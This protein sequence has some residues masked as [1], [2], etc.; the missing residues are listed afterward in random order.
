MGTFGE[1]VRTQ[2]GET[3]SRLQHSWGSSKR[4][5]PIDRRIAVTDDLA[6]RL[7][8]DMTFERAIRRLETIVG[9]LEQDASELEEGL[10]LYEEG[11]LL[12]RFCLERL[13]VAELRVQ[14]LSTD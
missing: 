1:P 5:F 4:A 3:S 2:A 9:T 13:D 8:A 7:P 11:V 10:Q 12:A 14:D 6:D